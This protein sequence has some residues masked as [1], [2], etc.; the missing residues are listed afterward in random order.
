LHTPVLLQQVIEKLDVKSAGKYIDATFGQ[1]GY[2]R[3]I[4]KKGARVLAIDLNISQIANVSASNFPHSN[5]GGKSQFSNLKLIEGNFKDIERLAKENEFFPVDGVV[6]DLGLSMNQIDK[7]GRGFSYKKLDEPLDMRLD[8]KGD[9]KAS[10]LLNNYSEKDLYEIFAR[11]GEEINSAKIAKEIIIT[12]RVIRLEKVGDLIEV[13]DKAVNTGFTGKTGTYARIF[14]AL[15]I[16][17]NNEFENLKH[18]L[19]GAIKI[20]KPKGRIVIVTFHSLE[21]R[22]VKNFVRDNKLKLL[23]KKPI[24]GKRSFERSAKIR[25]MESL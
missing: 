23:D 17:V 11:Y 5:A 16:K 18:G 2:T 6:F 3:E 8:L 20:V 1:G 9:V 25:V 13:I 15:R 4:L 22:I 19:S 21:D 10:D 7:S 14:Q 12:R 24:R